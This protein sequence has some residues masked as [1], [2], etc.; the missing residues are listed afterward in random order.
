MRPLLKGGGA[1]LIVGESVVGQRG[2]SAEH[3]PSDHAHA[4]EEKEKDEQ[5]PAK[6]RHARA[7]GVS[8]HTGAK[9]P[10]AKA[11]KMG[12][13]TYCYIVRSP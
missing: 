2:P 12:A 4:D 11:S 9:L 8:Q 13:G 10:W 1:H 5:T 7:A 3:F 6:M